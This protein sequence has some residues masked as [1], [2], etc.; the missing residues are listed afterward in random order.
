M[1]TLRTLLAAAA[2]AVLLP[3]L[4]AAQRT[5]NV[6]DADG[7]TAAMADAMPGDD[8]VLA[9]GDYAMRHRLNTSA[10]GTES[11]R[12]TVRAENPGRANVLFRDATGTVEGFVVSHPYW[13]FED[14]V[15][16]GDCASEHECEHAWH[17]VVDADFTI[18]RNNVARNFNA[19]IK[20]NGNGD[21]GDPRFPDD[22][23]VEGN[24]F[25]SETVRMTDRPVTPIDVVGGRRWIIRAN[26]IHDF[27]KGMGNNVSYAA[28]LKG[29]SRDGI[30]E[31]NLIV[32]EQLHTG[33]VRLGLSFGGGGS[34]PDRICEDG[35]CSIEHQGGIMRNNI[36]AHC[37]ADVGI[38][39]NECVDCALLHNT[40]YDTTGIDVRFGVS[41][42]VV[43]GNILSGRIRERDGG[44]ATASN[45]LEMVT[46][47][48][49]WFVDPDNLD[50]T[51]VDGATF[52][53][54]GVASG[55]VTDD[56][57]GRVRED[58]AP[59]LGAVEYDT[60][61]PCDT[62]VVHPG[63]SVPMPGEDAG[64]GG[65]DAG[66]GVG[67]GP[68][69]DGGPGSDSGPRA[70]G[71]APGSDVRTLPPSDDGCGCRAPVSGTAPRHGLLVLGAL[72]LFAWRRR[73]AG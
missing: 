10:A 17:V 52:V 30:I 37:P 19:Q 43:D 59:D 15:L 12:I 27:A 67:G 62:S 35:D 24:E 9:N 45:N 23:L 40:V 11:A 13:T 46:A 68:G 33:Q 72:S 26:Y 28:F 29:N 58:G 8:I 14:L 53:D 32:C 38:Y 39:V 49:S 5:V 2:L 22:V 3:T 25:Y 60:D 7:L 51:R 4:A 20:G 54:T 61:A 42:V 31:R 71:G 57:C 48:N 69:V 66:P 16:V 34:N 65:R 64:P 21:A 47:W 50:F 6:S 36:I 55:D 63:G 56:Y 18:I 41:T 70:D 73:R 44:T 1:S